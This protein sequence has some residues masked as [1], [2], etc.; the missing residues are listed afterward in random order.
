MEP[1]ATRPV[2]GW[3]GLGDQGLPMAAAIA[4][5]GYPLH[6]WARRP[7][8]AAA[9][10]GV[11]YVRHD[12]THD[13]GAACDIVGLCVGTDDDVLQIVSGGLLDALR[14]GAVVVNHGTGTP[15]NAVRLTDVCA[16]AAVDV[17]DAPVSGG[18]PAAEA[19]TLT[20]LVGGPEAVARSCEPVFRSFSRN[21]V[22]LGRAGSGQRAKLFN[23]ALLMMHQASIAE[24]ME[25]ASRIGSDPVRLVETLRLGGAESSALT[26]LNAMVT[27]EAVEHL[28]TVEAEAMEVFGV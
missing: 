25:L 10:D 9:L 11:P 14:P 8:S 28:S 5:A 6:V 26:L 27:P 12:T 7:A 21:V 4:A 17:L 3:I 2:V 19:K 24:L 15:E 22:Y 13:L 16:A 23:N 20:T 1:T 18:R